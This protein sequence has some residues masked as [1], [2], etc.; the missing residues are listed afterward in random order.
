MPLLLLLLAGGAIGGGLGFLIAR[1]SCNIYEL[2][3]KKSYE[4]CVKALVEK[5][6]LNP[7]IAKEVCTYKNM[8]LD[9]AKLTLLTA[10]VVVSF[11]AIKVLESLLKG[12]KNNATKYKATTT[13]KA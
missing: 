1:K 12:G 3:A 13:A 7:K 5:K 9:F 10:G 11:S 2:Q 6:K 4:E 8:T